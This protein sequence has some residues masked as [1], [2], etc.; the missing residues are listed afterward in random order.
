VSESPIHLGTS[1]FTAKGWEGSFYPKGLKSADY[2]SFYAEH[3]DTVEVDSTFYAC[4]APH[5]VSNWAAKTPAE[6]IF[7]VKVPQTITHEK[8]LVQC[9]AEFAQFVDTMSLLRHKLGPIVF[10]FP[11]FNNWNV[12]NQDEFLGVLRRFLNKLSA[13]HKF[14]IEIRNK[15]W[16]NARLV[17]VLKE[18]RVALVLQDLYQMPHPSE[19]NFDPITTDWTYIRWLGNRKGIEA[20]TETWDK[21]VE[22]KTQRLSSWVDYCQV[23]Q[24]RGIIQYVY[25]NNHF[26]G[27]GPA[28]IERFRNLWSAKGLPELGKP[29]RKRL[30][31]TL[32][33]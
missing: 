17:D 12:T 21:I 22:D 27:H 6:F 11:Y 19:L 33:D 32:F 7:S 31:P 25:A 29:I 4:P 10:Q 20:I 5:T 3:F 8:I 14:A 13:N 26:E 16:L 28:T 18:Y 1:S 15:K 30:E 23:I 2:L 24:K 9:D